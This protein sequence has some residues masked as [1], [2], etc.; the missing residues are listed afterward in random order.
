M[1]LTAILTT[2]RK[3]KSSIFLLCLAVFLCSCIISLLLVASILLF[4]VIF[5]ILLIFGAPIQFSVFLFS[6]L[7]ICTRRLTAVLIPQGDERSSRSR[8]RKYL[9]VPGRVPQSPSYDSSPRIE[10][11]S[12]DEDSPGNAN[13]TR[14]VE[15]N[16]IVYSN[17]VEQLRSGLSV[18]TDLNSPNVLG[19]SLFV[20]SPI[21]YR[22]MNSAFAKYSPSLFNS[23]PS[24][25]LE[26]ILRY[27][28]ADTTG[29][30]ALV[31]RNFG[32]QFRFRRVHSGTEYV[33]LMTFSLIAR[34]PQLGEHVLRLTVHPTYYRPH[35]KVQWLLEGSDPAV[36]QA[37]WTT[38][39]EKK[40]ILLSAVI[41]ACRRISSLTWNEGRLPMPP[42]ILN[43]LQIRLATTL[44]NVD[45]HADCAQLLVHLR[46][47]SSDEF[48]ALRLI[49]LTIR[50]GL[51]ETTVPDILRLLKSTRNSLR[52]LTLIDSR[53]G[54]ANERLADMLK[55]GRYDTYV[56]HPFDVSTGI[57]R[58]ETYR[59]YQYCRTGHKPNTYRFS[60][61][62][63]DIKRHHIASH[64][65]VQTFSSCILYTSF[66][67]I[68]TFDISYFDIHFV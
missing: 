21:D 54:T 33:P 37:N 52:Y 23:L 42:H 62:T 55:V 28:P 5:P 41:Q 48:D 19:V 2:F 29:T 8:T 10:E 67:I 15:H 17:T 59:I 68:N 44:R 34:K 51:N 35:V 14:R 22:F 50:G 30:L 40:L 53:L 43:T 16:D 24:T 63:K 11:L 12:V 38:A 46:K 60:W 13:I 20:D 58:F 26:E 4:V 3:T 25:I 32:N 36:L 49:S 65:I 7:G 1:V 27:L 56:T 64:H 6:I 66:P 39:E 61:S 57:Y 9:Q 18:S 31:S 45:I 47:T